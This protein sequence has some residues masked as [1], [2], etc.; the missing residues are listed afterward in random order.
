MEFEFDLIN[1]IMGVLTTIFVLGSAYLAFKK[2]N[3]GRNDYIPPTLPTLPPNTGGGGGG[4]GVDIIDDVLD[5]TTFPTDTPTIIADNAW[6]YLYL[7]EKV[8]LYVDKPAFGKGVID[9]SKRL[10]INPNWVMAV[11]HFESRFKPTAKN[12]YSSATGLIQFIESTAKGLGT[13]T[14]QLYQMTAVEQLYYVEKYLNQYRSHLRDFVSVYLAVFYPKAIVQNWDYNRHFGDRIAKV[15]DIFVK[16]GVLT[17]NTIR[18][19]LLSRYPF[20]E[21]NFVV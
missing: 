7:I 12:P 4:G 15:N 14:A 11:M 16:N 21:T 13:S 6:Q 18:Q 10:G 9:L 8:P 20:S 3:E 5:P 19:E 1:Y 2:S 17:I